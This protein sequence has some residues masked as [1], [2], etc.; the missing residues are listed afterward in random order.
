M[1]REIKGRGD[2]RGDER[3]I[4]GWNKRKTMKETQL[5]KE[6]ESSRERR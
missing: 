6:E 5:K 4:I 3:K 2:R 1:G